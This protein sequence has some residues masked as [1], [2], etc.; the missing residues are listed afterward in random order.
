MVWEQDVRVIVMLTAEEEGGRLKCH[1]YW[2][3]GTYGSLR[4]NC[5]QER[6]VSLDPSFLKGGPKRR[7]LSSTGQ[8]SSA[9][10]SVPFITVRKFTLD[11]MGQ[12]FNPLRE[13]TQ[14]QYSGWPDF[15]TPA[16]PAH[17][18]ALVE[19]TDAVVRS[20][21][22]SE[23]SISRRPVLVHCSAGCGRTGTFCTIDSVISMMKRQRTY[24][25][26]KRQQ[27]Q[28][29]SYEEGS[30]G[31]SIT[32]PTNGGMR[33]LDLGE[34]GEDDDWM[35]RDDEDLVYKAVCDFRDQR[36]SMVQCLQQYVLCY[37][38]VLEWLAKQNPLDSGKRKA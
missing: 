30:D 8:Q 26:R 17:V 27:Q 3:T 1:N 21:M 7:S 34:E 5:I 32:S 25:R 16:H 37:E 38:A 31:D 36:I 6:K 28:N 18:L 33:R 15:G 20:T 13:I 22:S 35:D 23:T 12:P 9:D 4:L 24:Q 19:H 11:H 10:A 2:K 14:L 29:Q